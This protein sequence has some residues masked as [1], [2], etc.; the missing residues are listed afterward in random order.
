MNYTG[1]DYHNR[2]LSLDVA[3]AELAKILGYRM[4]IA[5]AERDGL[6]LH[7]LGQFRRVRRC[8]LEAWGAMKVARNDCF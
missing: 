5:E 6:R 2:L 3:E 8:D 1:N 4:R 7:R